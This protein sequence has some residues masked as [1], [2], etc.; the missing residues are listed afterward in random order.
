M[1]LFNSNFF[2]QREDYENINLE[3]ANDDD[4]GDMASG[5]EDSAS[6]LR[7]GSMA[8]DATLFDEPDEPPMAG[9]SGSRSI[10]EKSSLQLDQPML[11]DGFGSN[12]GGDFGDSGTGGGGLF[13]EPVMAEVSTQQSDRGDGGASFRRNSMS[14]DGF[15]AGTYDI[16]LSI[17]ILREINFD[18][19]KSS[20]TAGFA[21]LG[22]QF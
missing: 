9:P 4:F 15:D 22:A 5:Y 10:R 3:A 11:D 8:R 20:K 2:F 21:I 16:F 18:H 7:A 1:K 12:I 19:F 14:D 6:E 17:Q 13:D